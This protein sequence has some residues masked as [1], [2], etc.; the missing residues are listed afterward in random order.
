MLKLDEVPQLINVLRGEMGFFGPRPE[1]V[2]VVEKYYE[3]WMMESLEVPPGIVGPGSLGYYLEED[4]L[5]SDPIEAEQYYARVLLPRKIARDLVYVRQPSF[6]YRFELL[7]RTMLGIIGAPALL[8]S[9][10][11]REERTAANILRSL[12][13]TP[14]LER[15][16]GRG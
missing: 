12:S 10:T 4:Q 16:P 1:S 15:R 5:P 13:E 8:T 11:E 9:A 3:P 6:G 2:D 7:A 14:P